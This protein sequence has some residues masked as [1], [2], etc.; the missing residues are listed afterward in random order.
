[1][2]FKGVRVVFTGVRLFFFGVRV[3]LYTGGMV[4]LIFI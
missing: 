3:V 4:V 2:V 1:M